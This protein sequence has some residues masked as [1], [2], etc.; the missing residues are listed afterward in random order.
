MGPL[1]ISRLTPTLVP[2]PPNEVLVVGEAEI[3]RAFLRIASS[4]ATNRWIVSRIGLLS[5]FDE[6]GKMTRLLIRM[7]AE[8]LWEKWR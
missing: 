7:A 3:I 5:I 8:C 1:T 4:L 2:L 6:D